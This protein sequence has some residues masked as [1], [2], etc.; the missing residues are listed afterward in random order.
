MRNKMQQNFLLL[1]T[2]GNVKKLYNDSNGQN[3]VWLK[4]L[5]GLSIA[6]KSFMILLPKRS[7]KQTAEKS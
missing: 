7:R 5:T 1:K 2:F 3:A 6:I 4:K